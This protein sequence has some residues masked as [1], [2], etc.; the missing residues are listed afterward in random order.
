[1]LSLIQFNLPLLAVALLIG[2]ATGRWMFGRRGGSDVADKDE[3]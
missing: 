2:L 1:M 3:P